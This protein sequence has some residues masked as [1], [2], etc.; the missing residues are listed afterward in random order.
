L[1]K[2][3]LTVAILGSSGAVGEELMILLEERNF[4]IKELRLLA[5]ERS[6]GKR[7]VGKI[8]GLPLNK[9]LKRS[10]KVLI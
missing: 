7:N 10:L 1:P 2:K 4:P 6:A 3:P 5:S 8:N 9:F